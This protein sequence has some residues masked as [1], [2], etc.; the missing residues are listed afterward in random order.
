MSAH[1]SK[2]I[3]SLSA[4]WFPTCR[5]TGLSAK[6]RL[7]HNPGIATHGCMERC[8]KKNPWLISTAMRQSSKDRRGRSFHL[9]VE[10][11]ELLATEAVLVV[12]EGGELR[13]RTVRRPC[14]SATLAG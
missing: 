10:R 8:N 2:A 9:D 6:C 13:R 4:K 12:H 1:S 7:P 3:A 14:D 5:C 11:L